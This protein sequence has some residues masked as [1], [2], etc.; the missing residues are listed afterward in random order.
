MLRSDSRTY[1][2]LSIVLVLFSGGGQSKI[3]IFHTQEP[4]RTIERWWYSWLVVGKEKSRY[5]TPKVGRR[6]V[7]DCV[8][9]HILRL[10]CSAQ[11]QEPTRTLLRWWYSWV[12]VGKAKSRYYTPEVGIRKIQDC[13][14]CDI[15]GFICS[16][17]PQEPTR[18]LV[19][20]WY[21]WVVVGRA[22]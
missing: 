13:V 2:H 3:K 16:A 12:V 19:R 15:L 21:S 17:Q 5:C 14:K 9:C 11:P 6:K 4:T 22:K 18:T 1:T 7:T 20:W 8:G 10:L